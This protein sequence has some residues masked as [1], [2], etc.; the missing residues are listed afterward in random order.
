MAVGASQKAMNEIALPIASQEAKQ[1]ADKNITAQDF[2]Q[3]TGLLTQE[4]GSRERISAAELASREGIS[5]AEIG[6]RE[7]ISTAEIAGRSAINT[8]DLASKE[9]IAGM[10]VSATDRAKAMES[11]AALDSSYAD[12]FRTIAAAENIPANTRD[13]YL[14]HIKAL[15]DS[16][17]NLLEQMYGID[18]TWAT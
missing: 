8:A 14:E 10:N 7:G 17:L 16:N 6:S 4:L 13:R 12:I 1:T 18:L 3:R 5:G 2:A 15:R 11:I 9:R